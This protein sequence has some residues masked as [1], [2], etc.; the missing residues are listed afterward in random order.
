M[1]FVQSAF[2]G[3]LAAVAVPVIV[4]LLFRSRARRVNLG[5]LRF[6]RQVL[7]RTAQRQRI[8]R[9]LLLAMRMTVVALLALLFARP[10]LVAAGLGGASKLLVVLIDSSATMDLKQE[11]TRL[12]DRAIR[13]ARELVSNQPARTRV[14]VAF[15]D[16]AVRPL[17]GGKEAESKANESNDPKPGTNRTDALAELSRITPPAMSHR[18]TD[19]GAAIAWARDICVRSGLPERELHLFTD[20]QRSGLDWS[21]VD[22]LPADTKVRLHDLGRPVV[23]NI[24]VTEVRG[25]ARWFDPER[26]RRSSS[27]C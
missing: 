3:A 7:E 13:E 4:H 5:T 16:H 25:C 20:F 23:N 26:G 19:Y 24:G 6:L 11:G 21:E 14:E 22:P 18:A 10:Y 1:N 27:R 9:W 2:L 8:M 12:V 17:Q 15:F